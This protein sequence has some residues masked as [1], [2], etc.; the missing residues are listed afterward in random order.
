M[1]ILYDLHYMNN[2]PMLSQP[3]SV[4]CSWLST[5]HSQL[6]VTSSDHLYFYAVR[7]T[8]VQKCLESKNIPKQLNYKRNK[9]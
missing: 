1:Y 2:D 5:F 7:H 6:H 9:Y 3:Y 8:I 4:E